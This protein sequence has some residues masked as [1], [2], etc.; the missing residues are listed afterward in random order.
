MRR[1]WVL[2]VH[3]RSLKSGLSFKGYPGSDRKVAT[4]A[5]QWEISG[6]MLRIRSGPTKIPS[7][8]SNSS[9]TILT[10]K[11]RIVCSH[12]FPGEF[13]ESYPA[14]AVIALRKSTMAT[15]HS[16]L[17]PINGGFNGK[18]QLEMPDV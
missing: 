18:A 11:P 5:L 8:A 2:T 12:G 16:L 6:M 7:I 3:L 15:E 17:M 9:S 1:T 13:G 10:L 4:S 14:T